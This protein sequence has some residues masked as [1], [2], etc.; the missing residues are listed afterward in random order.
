M[1]NDNSVCVMIIVD[2]DN[3]VCVCARVWVDNNDCV[4]VSVARA[5]VRACE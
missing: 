3:S 1:C 4:I 2:N 5:R